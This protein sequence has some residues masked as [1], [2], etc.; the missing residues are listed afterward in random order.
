MIPRDVVAELYLGD[1][2][3]VVSDLW[4]SDPI[5]ITRGR[6]DGASRPRGRCRL[7]LK[8]GSRNYSPRNTLGAH[9]GR[10][11]PNTPLRLG[12]RTA[13]DA[14]ERTLSTS[15]GSAPTGQAWSQ[16]GAGG[17]LLPSDFSVTDG[18]GRHS[19][20]A[21]GAYRFTYLATLAYEDI[22]VVVSATLPLTDVTGAEVHPATI[23]L[24]GQSV[25]TYYLARVAITPA[26]AITISLLHRAEDSTLTT[27][28]APVTV[29]GLTHSST[30][31]LR[32][33][34][35]IEGQTLRAKVW[36]AA[37]AEP[38]DWHVSAHDERISAPGWIGIRSGIASGNTN[39]MPVVIAYDDL[40]VTLRRF[41]GEI[42]AWP[43]RRT[44]TNTFQ[45]CPLEAAGIMHRLEQADTDL[46]WSTLRRGLLSDAIAPPVAYWPC[47]DEEDS[48]YIASALSNGFPLR[49]AT[50]RPD[51]AANADFAASAALPVLRG[52]SWE[53]AVPPYTLAGRCQVR[54]LVSVP[55]GGVSVDSVLC[56][57]VTFGTIR[58]LTVTVNAAGSLALAAY[59]AVGNSVY[60]SG[61]IAYAVN[62]APC[63]M[64]VEFEQVGANVE[65][66]LVT[67][68]PG[69]TSGDQNPATI[70]SHTIS[71][72]SVIKI[73]P[74]N[75]LDDVAMGHISI[76]N[77]WSSLFA[78]GQQLNAWTGETAGNR[79]SRLC[80]EE[81]IPFSHIGSLA[82]TASM[83]PQ[84]PRALLALLEEA[85]E[86][87]LGVL[88]EPRGH[89][90]LTYRTRTSL[91]NQPA[92][93]SMEYLEC[94]LADD[95]DDRLTRNDITVQ[96]T[97]GSAAR[98][99]LET[100]RMSVLPPD[101]GG[102]GRYPDK[103][104]V[105]VQADSQLRDMA[106]WVLHLGTVDEPRYSQVSIELATAAHLE[107]QALAV[108]VDD[109]LII[110]DAPVDQASGDINQLAQGYTEVIRPLQ[111][112][113]T[114]HCS[115]ESPWHVLTFDAGHKWGTSGS[116]LSGGIDDND[117]SFAVATTGTL[118]T[119]DP[120]Q[121]PILLDLGGENISVGA[122]SGS[123]SPQTFSQ[124]T[125]SV[126]GVVKSHPTG[127]PVHLTHRT[128]FTY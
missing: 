72:V 39:T 12:V 90:G 17:T 18:A 8:N 82:T 43:Q 93:L 89:P 114:Y 24:R 31:V 22:D 128:F 103:L 10:I 96:R 97:G 69:A 26:E 99:V 44:N 108:D 59:D 20:P 34:A 111:H 32:V 70:N 27:L 81:G 53:S 6:Q 54:M 88:Y 84:R 122:I 7:S 98:V 29:P 126:N 124:V 52:S 76:H 102:V 118:W 119:T 36:A 19:V 15:W 41:A 65:V 61:F 38:Y 35:S 85:A 57:I 92:A 28:A 100:G 37:G 4:L 104:T 23:L 87:D 45:W 79:L 110:S 49:F 71:I 55:A 77:V 117:I 67:V 120:A 42:P 74:D 112:E 94:R 21:A 60:N 95:E 5:T 91:I 11:G 121:M 86:A 68:E 13:V 33:R 47:E 40:E 101:Q 16:T 109:R 116:T 9:F 3:D 66:N 56:T 80:A 113:L 48:D 73:N 106:G 30:Q 25:N 107:A 14:F 2:I 78:L 125:R 1:W 123:S 75:V 51:F 127:T 46:V 83:G 50:T 115:P 64:S 63:W 58:T 105:N 62:G